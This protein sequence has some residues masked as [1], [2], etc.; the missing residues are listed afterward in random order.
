LTA[1]HEDA[2]TDSPK[3]GAHAMNFHFVWKSFDV[4]TKATTAM[5]E[6]TV[7][8]NDLVDAVYNWTCLHSGLSPDNWGNAFEIISLKEVSDEPESA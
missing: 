4:T 1:S 2:I 8:G 6:Q 7:F 3:Q 5:Y